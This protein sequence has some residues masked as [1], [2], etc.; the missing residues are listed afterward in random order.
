[1]AVIE[2]NVKEVRRPLVREKRGTR[3]QQHRRETM[4]SERPTEPL[5][6][7][8]APRGAQVSIRS[9]LSRGFR[10]PA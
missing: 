8:L 10:D 6:R 7:G 2:I 5:P 9:I 4:V 3:K 1:E